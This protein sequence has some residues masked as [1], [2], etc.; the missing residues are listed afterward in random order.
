[1]TGV[2]IPP[3]LLDELETATLKDVI[4]A[5]WHFQHLVT[6]LEE[7]TDQED[8]L[9]PDLLGICSDIDDVVKRLE[10]MVA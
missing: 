5:A 2:E 9:Y 10:A 3:E 1:M 6:L 8:Y 7:Q 4:E